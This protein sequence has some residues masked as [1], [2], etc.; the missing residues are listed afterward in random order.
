MENKK[1]R[2]EAQRAAD[3]RYKEKNKGKERNISFCFTREEADKIEK[4][5]AETGLSKAD[6]LRRAVKEIK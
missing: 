3:K 2:S 4:A 5:I 6:F 1:Q